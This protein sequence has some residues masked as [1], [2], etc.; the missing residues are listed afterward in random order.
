MI[1]PWFRKLVF[2]ARLG[3]KIKK[4][5]ANHISFVVDHVSF[6][7][8]LLIN[9]LAINLRPD[10]F[11]KLLKELATTGPLDYRTT[12]SLSDLQNSLA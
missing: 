4:E 5:T 6:S 11:E 10:V 7:R 2:R 8:F 3:F 9:Q 12:G 1:F